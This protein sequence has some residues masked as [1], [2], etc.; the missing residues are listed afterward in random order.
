MKKRIGKKP[1]VFQ[2]FTISFLVLVLLGSVLLYLPIAT[3]DGQSTS[4]IN[5][6]FTATSATCV[7]GLITYDTNVHFTLFGQI[8]ILC[9]IQIGGLGF[10][11]FISVAFYLIKGKMSVY[12]NKILAE[13]AGHGDFSSLKRI[14]KRIIITTVVFELLGALVLSTRFVPIYGAKGLYVAVFTS[15]SAFCNAGF[16]VLTKIGSVEFLSLNNF[17]LDPIVII[18]ICTLVLVGGFGFFVWSDL[19]D[20]KF[21]FKKLQLYTKIVLITNLILV[22]ATTL[23]FVLVTNFNETLNAQFKDLN[24]FEKILVGFFNAVTPRT[25]GFSIIDY[26]NLSDSGY[27]LTIL[28]MFIGGNSCSTAGGVKI[29]TISVLLITAI[30]VYRGRE[31]TSCYNKE[32]SRATIKKAI[33]VI[34]TYVCIVIVSL[35]L[36]LAF[37]KDNL[38]VNFKSALFEI[39]SALATVGL[40]FG[41]TPTLTIASKLLLI[42]LMF[43]GRVGVITIFYSL[44]DRSDKFG[45]KKPTTDLMVG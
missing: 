20:S 10:M 23:L 29:N 26:N 8:V 37:E 21:K 15:I 39:V 45:A 40:S 44:K 6:L 24:I 16:D 36:M 12:Q 43:A 28:T 32:I 41:I 4:Y 5:A 9:L 3:R 17:A 34:F 13:I 31:D 25:A 18:T 7:T 2:L 14:L 35:F 27:I 42:L 33:A 22:V 38:A 19:I 30:S 1:S 11:T